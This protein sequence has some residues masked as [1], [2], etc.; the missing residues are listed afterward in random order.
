MNSFNYFLMSLLGMSSN[1]I[2][3]FIGNTLGNTLSNIFTS[4]CNSVLKPKMTK[5]L[6]F[7]CQCNYTKQ[8]V[9]DLLWYKNYYH[10]INLLFITMYV[11][12]FFS[13]GFIFIK[14]YNCIKFVPK[15]NFQVNVDD[16]INN[17]LKDLEIMTTIKEEPEL[18]NDFEEIPLDDDQ[19][20]QPKKRKLM[21]IKQNDDYI[22]L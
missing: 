16:K 19:P 18:D 7:V 3:T 17:I 5:T 1:S 2:N 12:T 9:D 10:D 8:Y 15:N 21:P 13:L 22:K 20:P 4:F 14:S 6:P 11:V